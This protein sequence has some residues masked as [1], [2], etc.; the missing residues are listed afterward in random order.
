[1]INQKE[2]SVIVQGAI[3][4]DLTIKSL[5]SIKKHLPKSHI[6]VSTW[7]GADVSSIASLCDE[8]VFPQILVMPV[9]CTFES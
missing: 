1:M 3:I 2:I 9:K 4:P 7:D 5:T 8:I 6:I